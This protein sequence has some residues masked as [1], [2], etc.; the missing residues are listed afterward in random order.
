MEKDFLSI[1]LNKKLS[2]KILIESNKIL[3]PIT[4]GKKLI[5]YVHTSDF[6]FKEQSETKKIL[7]IGGLGFIGSVL[8]KNLLEKKLK[9]NILDI[10][11][12]G[13]KLE[14]NIEK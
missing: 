13:C 4:Q 9:V 5:D 14:K 10:N 1:P 7:V 12:Y 8:V 3:I 2:K 6:F 11:F